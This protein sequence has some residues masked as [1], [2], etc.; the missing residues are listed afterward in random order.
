MI[1]DV[2]R[3]TLPREDLEALQLTRL[4]NLCERVYAN[5]PHYRRRFD[6]A[7]ISPADIRKL[8]DLKYLPFTE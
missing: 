6:E 4:R 3:E 2:D 8:S 5:V 7:G 1:F